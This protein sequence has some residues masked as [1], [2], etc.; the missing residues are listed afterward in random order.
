MTKSW[1][2]SAPDKEPTLWKANQYFGKK[3]RLVQID[4]KTGIVTMEITWTNPEQAAAWANGLVAMTN[5]YLRSEAIT[6]A[7]RNIDYLNQQAANT[8]LMPVKQVIYGILENEINKEMLARGTKEYALKVLD[9]AQPPEKP[10][11]LRLPVWVFLGFA[12][13]L[14][15]SLLLA[16]FRIVWGRSE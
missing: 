9:P 8:T 14:G 4:A 16:F 6:E 1:R 5:D 10:S 13:G 15:L 3:I 12:G 2:T 7:Q 11:S